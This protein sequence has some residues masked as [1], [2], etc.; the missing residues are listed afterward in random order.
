MSVSAQG[1]EKT[2]VPAHR[3]AE[4]ASPSSPAFCLGHLQQ[5]A[6]GHPPPREG[7]PLGAALF[8]RLI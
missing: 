7:D 8:Q 2:S 5:L 3:Q 1:Q 4:R 6:W